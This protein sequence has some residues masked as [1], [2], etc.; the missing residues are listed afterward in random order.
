M[1]DH[2][3]TIWI[4]QRNKSTVYSL[5]TLTFPCQI[6]GFHGAED[7]NWGLLRCGTSAHLSNVSYG[8]SCQT[9]LD[10]S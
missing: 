1:F 5:V 7:S 2:K 9:S 10:E 4:C 8:D 3:G 6:S